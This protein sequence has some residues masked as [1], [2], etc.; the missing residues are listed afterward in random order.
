MSDLA[1]VYLC[2]PRAAGWMDWAR[3]DC[4]AASLKLLRLHAPPWPVIIFHEDY[5][6][7][8]KKRLTD[9]AGDITFEKIDLSG[10]EE[11]HINHRPDNRVG[12]Y[13]YNMMCRFFAGQMQAHP[14]LQKYSHYMRLDDDS[15]LMSPLTPNIVEK[16]MSSDYTYRCLYQEKHQDCWNAALAFMGQDGLPK[17]L[18]YY[19]MNSPYNN[20]HTSSLAMWRHPLVKKFLAQIEAEHRHVRDGWTDTA[21]QSAI[22]WLLGPALGF[23]IHTE[24][25]FDY[26]HNLHCSHTGP[27]GKYCT[28]HIGGKLSWGPPACLETV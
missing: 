6:D 28:D 26:R 17:T 19:N 15:Y 4:L 18:R 13:G 5:T 1:V 27:H 2:S 11:F 10:Q 8:D 22:I 3:L 14:A 16:I 24:T 7:E 23:K 9:I 20:Y 25:G 12:T 21:V